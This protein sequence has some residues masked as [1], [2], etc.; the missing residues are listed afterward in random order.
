MYSKKN[1]NK[2]QMKIESEPKTLKK[3][4][5]IKFRTVNLSL[6]L[7]NKRNKRFLL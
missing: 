1:S 3:D 2:V 7:I 5:K 4:S 6:I